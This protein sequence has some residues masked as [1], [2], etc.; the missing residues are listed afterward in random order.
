MAKIFRPFSLALVFAL[1][2]WPTN[3]VR[4]AEEVIVSDCTSGWATLINGFKRPR[5]FQIPLTS[6]KA[7]ELLPDKIPMHVKNTWLGRTLFQTHGWFDF[8]GRRVPVGTTPLTKASD[9]DRIFTPGQWYNF[10]VEG[11]TITATATGNSFAKDT[12]S[13]HID[14]MSDRKGNSNFS[15][16]FY[17]DGHGRLYI[18]NGSGTFPTGPD[19]LPK[20]KVLFEAEFPG[21]QVTTIPHL[22][23]EQ[24]KARLLDKSAND[25]DGFFNYPDYRQ[26]EGGIF[27]VEGDLHLI[28]RWENY[29]KKMEVSKEKEHYEKRNK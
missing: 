10:N 12:I 17:L 19:V 20:I 6:G 7:P 14:L 27:D 2:A 22:T 5:V 3:S 13:K 15:G 1:L 26:K 21:V 4:A 9:L 16:S 23:V 24:F 18:T 29:F 8:L 25:Y 11:N 28:R